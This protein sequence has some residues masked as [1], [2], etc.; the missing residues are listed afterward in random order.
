MTWRVVFTPAAQRQL[1]KLPRE[2]HVRVLTAALLL[3]DD[4][5]PH[6][7]VRL[8]GTKTGWRVRVGDYRILY[9]VN[10][11]QLIVQIVR[12]AHRREAYRD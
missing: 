11:G 9:E 8:A 5:R 10:Q 3:A 4:P 7:A 6:G 1:R 2:A 12:V